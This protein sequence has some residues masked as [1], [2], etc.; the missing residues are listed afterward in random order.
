MPINFSFLFSVEYLFNL[1]PG[2]ILPI[3]FKVLVPIFGCMVITG[4]I[5]RK[6]TRHNSYPPVKKFFNK[7][8]HYLFTLGLLG[9]LYLFF[10]QQSIYLLSAPFWLVIWLIAALVWGGFILKYYFTDR[11]KEM[12]E[13]KNQK[14]K[15]KYLPN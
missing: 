10:R 2:P 1:N 12:D 11:P 3:Y 9:L 4:F 5:I 15:D 14:E 6:I 13:V 8:F 7:F